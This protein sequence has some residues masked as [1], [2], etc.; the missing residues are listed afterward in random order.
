[1][2]FTRQE[3]NTFTLEVVGESPP[4]KYGISKGKSLEEYLEEA[5][6][7][8]S[9]ALLKAL[10]DE[11]RPVRSTDAFEIERQPFEERQDKILSI[12]QN[13]GPEYE[14]GRSLVRTEFTGEY[15]EQQQELLYSGIRENPTLAIGVAKELVDS[16]AQTILL[17]R[18]V[19]YEKNLDSSS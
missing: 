5:D 11:W 14:H 9:I 16:C 8:H 1:M 18:D 7:V 13:L 6:R 10:L 12:E 3:F 15:L 19:F 17:K 2:N 4:E